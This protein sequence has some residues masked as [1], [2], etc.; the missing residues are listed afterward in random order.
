MAQLLVSPISYIRYAR[1]SKLALFAVLWMAAIAIMAIFPFVIAP[2]PPNRTFSGKSN[3]PPSLEFLL[4]TD[5][6]GRDILSQVIWGASTSLAIGIGAAMVEVVIGVPL[7]LFAGYYGGRLD[8]IFM[9]IADTILTIPTI[10]LL[11]VAVTLLRAQSLV[12][13]VI[14]MGF[15]NWVWL[16]KTLRGEA[17]RV[18]EEEYVT[19]AKAMG[20]SDPYIIAKHILSNVVAPLIVIVTFDIAWFILYESTMSFIGL[21]DP[22][23]P[24]WGRLLFIGRG[25]LNTAPWIS[26]IPGIFIF[27]TV[28]SFNIL[29]DDLTGF[30]GARGRRV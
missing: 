8:Q 24:S 18:R 6:V 28:L 29:G 12:S 26:V 11:I 23:I 15:V 25:F 22:T 3:L 5:N 20:F 9:R 19:A 21:G 1:K 2:H 17:L 13:I 30:L 7:G 27:L 16:A 14:V 4:G 10:V